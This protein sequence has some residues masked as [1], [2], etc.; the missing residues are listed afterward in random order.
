MKKLL[1][2]LGT[3][4]IVGIVVIVILVCV[5]FLGGSTEP[6]NKNTITDWGFEN[7][8]EL[9][10]EEFYY[11]TVEKY[12]GSPAKLFGV[13]IPFV[14]THFLYQISGYVKAGLNFEEIDVKVN[15]TAMEV[16]VTL[17]EISITDSSLDMNSVEVFD[18]SKNIFKPV[19]V[20]QVTASLQAIEDEAIKNAIEKGMLTRAEENAKVLIEGMMGMAIPEGY[21]LIIQ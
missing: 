8:G 6:T 10:T 19:T 3:A 12:E 11:T 2:F 21:T 18:E 13:E 7:I 14:K 16:I 1:R 4:G 17:P 9:N 15:D 20:E 5:F